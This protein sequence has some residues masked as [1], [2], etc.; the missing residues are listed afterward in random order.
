MACNHKYKADK[1]GDL[2]KKWLNYF[3]ACKERPQY[4]FLIIGLYKRPWL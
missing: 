4:L 3:S 2:R 1:A